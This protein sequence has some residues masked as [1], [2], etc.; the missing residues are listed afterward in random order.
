VGRYKPGDQV[1]LVVSRGGK[2]IRLTITMGPPQL[3]DYRIEEL[4]NAP[5]E[6]KARRVAWLNGK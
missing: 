6:A 4:P 1:P 2:I 3:F 5:L